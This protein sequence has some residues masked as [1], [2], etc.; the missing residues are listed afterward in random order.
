MSASDTMNEGYETHERRDVAVVGSDVGE[1]GCERCRNVVR[2]I[3]LS[4]GWQSTAVV[5]RGNEGSVVQ[6]QPGVRVGARCVSDLVVHL[7]RVARRSGRD[8]GRAD[9]SRGV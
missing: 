2:A 9:D 7:V 1:L 5:L 3:Q 4:A 8:A 6:A